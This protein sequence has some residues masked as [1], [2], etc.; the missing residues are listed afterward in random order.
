MPWEGNRGRSSIPSQRPQPT[1]LV[2]DTSCV[3]NHN[4]ACTASP[5]GARAGRVAKSNSNTVDKMGDYVPIPRQRARRPA[6][7]IGEGTVWRQFRNPTTLRL[8]AAPT[9]V[10]FSPVAPHDV[11]VASSLQV[12]IFSTQTNTVYRTLTRFKDIVHCASFRHDGKV[13]AA[14]DERGCTQ[15][16]DLGSRAVMRTFHGHE[17]AVHVAR[18]SPDSTRLFTA[19]D[20]HRALC[21]DVAAESQL[22]AFD[23]HED[24]VRSGAL[25]PSSP[26][27]FVTGSYDHTVRIWDVNAPRCIMTL[28]HAA[29]VEVSATQIVAGAQ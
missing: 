16:F 6:A 8:K 11:A 24:F 20:D 25:S 10:E 26:H 4:S 21:W 3:W 27:M 2:S 15:L 13:L 5:D 29:P 9:H 7:L 28:N 17:R 14:G 19:S 1:I 23:G 18:F 12:D 22:R